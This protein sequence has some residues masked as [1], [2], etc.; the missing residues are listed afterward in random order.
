LF[1]LIVNEELFEIYQSIWSRPQKDGS[2]QLNQTTAS[3]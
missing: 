2:I 3:L 1:S